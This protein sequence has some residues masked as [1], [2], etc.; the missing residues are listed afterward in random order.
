M[1]LIASYPLLF[2]YLLVYSF[3]LSFTLKNWN[4]DSNRSSN[5]KSESSDCQKQLIQLFLFSVF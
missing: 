1:Q 5:F 4:C 2:Q 3:F